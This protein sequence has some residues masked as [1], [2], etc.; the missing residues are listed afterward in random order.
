LTREGS[1]GDY[2]RNDLGESDMTTN[3]N[4]D[5]LRAQLEGEVILPG[6]GG[7]DEARTIFNAMHDKRPA[8]VARCAG[9]ADVVASAG[10]R[11]AHPGWAHHD[12]R[13]RRLH[14]R[15]RP[16]LDLVQ[17]RPHL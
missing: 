5:A 12:D 2:G 17:A 4:V 15:W 13:H 11:T 9:T 7:Y 1:G 6:D 14:H 16:W 3:G 8:A 10:A